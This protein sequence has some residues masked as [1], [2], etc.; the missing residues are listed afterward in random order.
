M[1][2]SIG[3]SV[4]YV[5]HGTPPRAD[6]SQAFPSACRAATITEVGADGVVGLCVTNPTGLFFHPLIAGGC[7]Y[8]EGGETPGSPDCP[9]PSTHG[10]PFRYCSCGWSEARPVGGTWHWPERVES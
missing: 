3:R 2:P 1:E 5:A 8:N 10:N 7:A 6:G 9:Q 4:H